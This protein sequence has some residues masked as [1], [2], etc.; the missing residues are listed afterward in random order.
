ML[1]F[2]EILGFG[3]GA[4]EDEEL[5]QNLEY[6]EEADQGAAEQDTGSFFSRRSA[7]RKEHAA[8]HAGSGVSNVDVVLVKPDKYDSATSIADDLNAHKAVVL[9]LENASKETSRRLVDFLSGVAYANG[10]DIKRVATNTFLITPP[11][12]NL[13]NSQDDSDLDPATYL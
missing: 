4:M 7:P 8:P 2:K 3:E 13:T 11:N 12:V 10:G 6:T 9:N 1:S 5:D